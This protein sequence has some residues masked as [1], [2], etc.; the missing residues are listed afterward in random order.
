[1]SAWR[2]AD[3][4]GGGTA[5]RRALGLLLE[6]A[7]LNVVQVDEDVYRRLRSAI[8]RVSL[9][10]GE[11]QTEAEL[12]QDI[13]L[14]VRE[15]EGY[16][17]ETEAMLEARRKEWRLMAAGLLEQLATFVGIDQESPMWRALAKELLAAGKAQE[18]QHLREKLTRIFQLRQDEMRAKQAAEREDQDRSTENHNAAGLRGGGAAIEQVQNMIEEGRPGFVALFRLSC[19]D[20]VGA[21]FGPDGI[22]DCKMAVSAF[23]ANNMHSEDSIYHWSESALMGVCESKLRQ[24]MVVAELNRILSHNR[25][26]TIKVGDRTIMLRIPVELQVYPISQFASG[27]ELNNLGGEAAGLD[28]SLGR[29]AI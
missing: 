15:L 16:R 6:G 21:R 28:R 26:F 17:S 25:D 12:L 1:M 24:E 2:S 7:A 27:E 20:V 29:K 9:R 23:L 3:S 11:P 5:E 18:I 8:L 14:A 22:E 13:G 19:L 4:D 10:I